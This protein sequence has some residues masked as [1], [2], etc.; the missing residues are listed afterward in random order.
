M[1]TKLVSL[2]FSFKLS[3]SL[4]VSF[5]ILRIL[6]AFQT[7]VL[8]KHII[9]WNQET[10]SFFA[11]LQFHTL[12]CQLSPRA[13]QTKPHTHTHSIACTDSRYTRI[14]LWFDYQLSSPETEIG[15]RKKNIQSKLKLSKILWLQFPHPIPLI[16]YNLES[17]FQ[18]ISLRATLSNFNVNIVFRAS[19]SSPSSSSANWVLGLVKKDSE[20]CRWKKKERKEKK[21]RGKENKILHQKRWKRLNFLVTRQ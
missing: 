13:C 9:T 5:L 17:N 19:A 14:Y 11:A 21:T 6:S 8:N 20:T 12:S 7:S 1:L 10:L 2:H 15:R 3:L 18:L 16:K 4:I